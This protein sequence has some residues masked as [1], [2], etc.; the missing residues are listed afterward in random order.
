MENTNAYISDDTT[1]MLR[2][3]VESSNNKFY[4]CSVGMN[5]KYISIKLSSPISE[6][7][8]NKKKIEELNRT[9]NLIYRLFIDDN[10]ELSVSAVFDIEKYSGNSTKAIL[11]VI[12]NLI[13]QLNSALIVISCRMPKQ[14]E[15]SI[16]L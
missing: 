13:A 12:T 15:E 16:S 8:D 3:K 10:N 2:T 11:D 6:C 4:N 14:S 7:D 5:N 1:E 9:G